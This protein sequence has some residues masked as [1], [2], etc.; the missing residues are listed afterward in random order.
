M[1]F[2]GFILHTH[3][4]WFNIIRSIVEVSNYRSALVRIHLG[5]MTEIRFVSHRTDALLFAVDFKPLIKCQTTCKSV[6]SFE[7]Y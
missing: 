2:Y 1:S 7:S 4:R 3:K 5:K 6:M